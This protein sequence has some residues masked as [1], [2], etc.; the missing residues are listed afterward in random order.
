MVTE[1]PVVSKGAAAAGGS[2]AGCLQLADRAPASPAAGCAATMVTRCDNPRAIVFAPCSPSED[3]HALA[4]RFP[5]RWS[6][7]S[8]ASS[9][10]SRARRIPATAL[11]RVRATERNLKGFR[12]PLL[13]NSRARSACTRAEVHGSPARPGASCPRSQHSPAP[14]TRFKV[15]QR[16][17]A[18][19]ALHGAGQY[20]RDPSRLEAALKLKDATGPGAA[21]V[22]T[23]PRQVEEEAWTDE[24]VAR[25]EGATSEG[26]LRAL[27]RHIE[28]LHLTDRV[29]AVGAG[30][31]RD[32]R[33]CP[34]VIPLPPEWQVR[35][36]RS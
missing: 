21:P 24:M 2:G 3:A 14:R 31:K 17:P 1:V 19:R 11:R 28:R 12:P 4:A 35:I 32:G 20:R 13:R 9:I 5:R 34:S 23:S 22:V 16:W 10:T 27:D 36:A 15:W 6:P 18:R 33:A 25:A 8:S 26:G 29:P 30:L 7:S